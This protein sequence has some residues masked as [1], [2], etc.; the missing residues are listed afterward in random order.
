MNSLLNYPRV[1]VGISLVVLWLS[2]QLGGYLSRHRRLRHS[3][4]RADFD[5][6]LGATLTLLALIIGFTFSMAITRY[7]QRKNDEEAEANAIGTEYLRAALLPTADAE[8][9]KALLRQYTDQRISF[10][11]ADGIADID[12]TTAELRKADVVGRAERGGNAADGNSR[13]RD[14]GNERRP[15]LPGLY[16]RRVA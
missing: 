6:V 10:Y 11:T 5:V 7:D 3:E 15:E 2:A 12:G 8:R 16:K 1:L 4:D 14:G 9:A 13:A